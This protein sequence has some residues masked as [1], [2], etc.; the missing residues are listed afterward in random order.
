MTTPRNHPDRLREEFDAIETAA[1][2]WLARREFGLTPEE[3]A[4][5]ERWLRQ[6]ERHARVFSELQMTA[7]IFDRHPEALA[8]TSGEAAGSPTGRAF[9]PARRQQTLR[10]AAWAALAAALVIGVFVPWRL[11]THDT[12]AYNLTA[13][14]EVGGLRTLTLPDGSVA[15]LNTDSELDIIYKATERRVRLARGEASF[16]VAKD[17]RRPFFVEARGVT[18]RAVGTEF[19]VRLRAAAVDV[20]VTEGRVR[21]ENA[22]AESLLPVRAAAPGTA[23]QP[24][25]APAPVLSAG[26]KVLVPLGRAT[27]EA[28]AAVTEVAPAEIARTLAWRERRLI[29]DDTPLSEVVAEF[30]RYIKHRLVIE[31]PNLGRRKFGGTFQP[32]RHET[33]VA[34]LEQSFGVIAERRGDTTILWPR[35]GR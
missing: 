5:L 27:P 26:E 17:S 11:A 10:A 35:A 14:T 4:E 3:S 15:R 19:V 31:D 13:Q 16:A 9:V 20:L 24:A 21:V 32:E 7:A 6:E 18:V 12:P 1:A 30:N 34:L 28:A 23:A 8:R 25:P 22:A 33:L 29:F 2:D